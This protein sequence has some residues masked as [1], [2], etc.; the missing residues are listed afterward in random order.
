MAEPG[1]RGRLVAAAVIGGVL[2][3]AASLAIGRFSVPV[4]TAPATTSVEAGFA[5]D[6]QVHHQQAVEL[7]MIVRDLTDDPDVRLLA[8]DI[9]ISQAQ[10]AGQMYGWLAEWGLPQAPAEPPMTWMTRPPI[11]EG[12]EQHGHTASPADVPATMPGFAAP[13][14]LAELSAATGVDAERIF[15]EL[16][17]AHH[18]GG[19]EMAE[20]VLDRSENRVVTDLASS[21][22]AAQ[23]SEIEL[24]QS[25]LADRSS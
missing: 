4:D 3:V 25:M 14:Q 16:M 22:L 20:S 23:S 9:T 17:I 18:E 2:L 10:Q 1:P 13:E 15:L 7:S 24:M 21:I 6:M 5:R 19:V 11:V 8:Y 12:G